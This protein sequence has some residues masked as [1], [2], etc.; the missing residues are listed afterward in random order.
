MDVSVIIGRKDK[1]MKEY[2]AL[3]RL[4]DGKYW[5]EFNADS[6]REAEGKA[7]QYLDTVERSESYLL[8]IE[9]FDSTKCY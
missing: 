5:K 2:M 9:R 7:I 1:I 6:F 3:F 8:R 4:D